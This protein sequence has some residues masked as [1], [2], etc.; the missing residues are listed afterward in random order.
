MTSEQQFRDSLRS[1]RWA[2]NSNNNDLNSNKTTTFS[3]LTEN[4][5]NFFGNVGNRVRGYVPLTNNNVEED[6]DWFVLT[7]WQVGSYALVKGFFIFY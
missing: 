6:D 3:R 1:F 7:R 4:T 2:S 5:S